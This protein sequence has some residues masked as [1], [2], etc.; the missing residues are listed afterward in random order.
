MARLSQPP[1]EAYMR[2]LAERTSVALCGRPIPLVD[3]HLAPE[4]IAAL[5]QQVIEV[6]A[7][8]VNPD[9]RTLYDPSAP[10]RVVARQAVP[11]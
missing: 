8:G 6:L 1:S 10:A 3:G 4:V 5:D 11:R 2:Q 7:E 9:T